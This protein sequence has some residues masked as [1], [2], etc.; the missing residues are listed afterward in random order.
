LICNGKYEFGYAG[1]STS[2]GDA[3][4]NNGVVVNCDYWYDL[5]KFL[6]TS[7]QRVAIVNTTD[8]ANNI[9]RII[10]CRI[11]AQKMAET[12]NAVFA[13]DY[14]R[15][16]SS[17]TGF[18]AINTILEAERQNRLGRFFPGLENNAANM[19]NCAFADIEQSYSN[20]ASPVVLA[21]LTP[22]FAA[23]PLLEGAGST[24]ITVDSDMTGRRRPATPSIGP[25][26]S[27]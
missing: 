21:G 5:S 16:L 7:L 17:S 15:L 27:Y 1:T 12:D 22:D 10:N 11:R 3:S 2:A 26:E 18:V 20:A 9:G 14:D 4:G 6:P 25:F 23:S 8:P 13:I 19:I 24:V